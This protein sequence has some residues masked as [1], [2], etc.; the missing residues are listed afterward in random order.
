MVLVHMQPDLTTSGNACLTLQ[1]VYILPYTTQDVSVHDI[2]Q[3]GI[4][5][6]LHYIVN[7]SLSNTHL[8]QCLHSCLT[9]TLHTN[10]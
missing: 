9:I 8:G 10:H 7:Q 6:G 4:T 5:A 2:V 3:L 1:A